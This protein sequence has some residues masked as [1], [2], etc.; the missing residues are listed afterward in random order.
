VVGEEEW[1]ERLDVAL[2]E[3]TWHGIALD[4]ERQQVSLGFDVL[5]L[6][7]EAGGE[8]HERVTLVLLGVTRIVA[9]LR[10]GRWDDASAEVVATSENDFPAVFEAFGSPVYGWEFFD[11]PEESWSQWRDRLSLNSEWDTRR[12]AHSLDLFQEGR[13]VNR[14]LDFRVWF[15]ELAVYDVEDRR[16]GLSAFAQG[17]VRWWEGFRAHDSR[18]TTSGLYPLKEE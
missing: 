18:T 13:V 14:H 3:G 10:L 15:D 16:I 5:T 17:G 4:P 12:A 1:P 11:Q 2:N 6:P 9:S 8:G 7:A